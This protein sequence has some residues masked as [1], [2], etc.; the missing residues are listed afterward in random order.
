MTPARPSRS[1]ARQRGFYASQFALR[2]LRDLAAGDS[3]GLQDEIDLL[4]V[5]MRRILEQGLDSGDPE[6]SIKALQALA[7]AAGKLASLSLAHARLT[8]QDEDPLL[9]QVLRAVRE[10]NQGL[11]S[12]EETFR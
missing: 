12:A 6:Q 4:K 2:E 10:I 3:P 7:A 11:P 5:A 9:E 1:R 8:G